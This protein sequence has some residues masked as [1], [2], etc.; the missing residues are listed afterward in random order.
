MVLAARR[1]NYL[2]LERK[3]SWRGAGYRSLVKGWTRVHSKTV[4]RE[5]RVQSRTGK[6]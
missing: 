2:W 1:S 6:E 5:V 3:A 4:G